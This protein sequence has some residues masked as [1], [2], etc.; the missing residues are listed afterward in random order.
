MIA[1]VRVEGI[2][3]AIRAIDTSISAG[4]KAIK[5]SI[6]RTATATKS[7]VSIIARETT[8]VKAK[9]AKKGITIPY[10]ATARSFKSKVVISGLRIPL[11]GYASRQNKKGVVT[12]IFKKDPLVLRPGAFIATM[13]SG[14][15]GVFW[16]EFRGGSL[17][18]GS[19]FFF[20]P[21]MT[22]AKQRYPN[23]NKI[24]QGRLGITEL[25]GP[26][27]PDLIKDSES[28]KRID[29]FVNNRLEKE[30]DKNYSYFLS[31]IP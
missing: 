13:K 4:R 15:K 25:H 3:E 19:H 7:Q 18:M 5:T 9:Y 28:F 11:V 26:A 17:G 12:R 21:A 24:H 8:T 29:V 30:L 22:A 2:D 20:Y 10:R 16:R 27:L 23:W 1:T 14:H 31:K 6:N